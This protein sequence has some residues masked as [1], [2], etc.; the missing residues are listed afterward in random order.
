M[1]TKIGLILGERLLNMPVE[2]VPP[3]YNMLLEEIQ[4][5]IDEVSQSFILKDENPF[6][7][8]YMFRVKRNT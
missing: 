7:Y 8:K 1:S 4:W 3:M 6:V 5:A 2:L